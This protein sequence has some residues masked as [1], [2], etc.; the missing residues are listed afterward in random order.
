MLEAKKLAKELEEWAEENHPVRK[1]L[2]Y[3]L[4][5]SI[6]TLSAAAVNINQADDEI[7]RLKKE[8]EALREV[9]ILQDS[10]IGLLAKC[11][12]MAMNRIDA[13]PALVAESGRIG[14]EL[15]RA[16]DYLSRLEEGKSEA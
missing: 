16:R 4:D 6:E 9:V 14:K 15:D 11:G 8:N 10:A 5:Q 3:L 7:A 12:K 2:Q 13:G 1:D